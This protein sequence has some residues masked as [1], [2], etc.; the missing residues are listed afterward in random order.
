MG[1]NV[2]K[3]NKIGEY[4]ETVQEKEWRS[5]VNLLELPHGDDAGYGWRW[6]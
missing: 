1:K 4:G 5:P 6:V 3:W 2:I